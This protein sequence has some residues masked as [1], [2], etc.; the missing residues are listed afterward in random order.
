MQHRV[1]AGQDGE[2]RGC[3]Q[4]LEPELVSIVI[5]GGRDISNRQRRNRL[6]HAGG[7]SVAHA[8]LMA[9]SSAGASARPKK[10]RTAMGSRPSRQVT[11]CATLATAAEPTTTRPS[12]T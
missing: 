8:R 2:V 1:V 9:S 4:R 7:G 6:P 5:Y 3:V 11:L 12:T 10:R